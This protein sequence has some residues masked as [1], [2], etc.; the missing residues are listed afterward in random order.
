MNNKNQHPLFAE[1]RRERIVLLLEEKGKLVVPEL[2]EAFEVSP[3][4][5]RG[6]LRELEGKGR[7]KRAHG[8]AMTLGKTGFERNSVFQGIVNMEEKRRIAEYAR[9]L[10]NDGDTIILDTGTT[11]LE[12]AKLLYE[13]KNLTVVTNDIIIAAHLESH[14]DANIIV[15]G[16][17]LRRGYHCTTGSRAI[18]ALKDL[19]V[20]KA[21]MASNALSLEKGFTTPNFEQAEVKRQMLSIALRSIMLIDSSKLGR[22]SFLKF[23]DISDIDLLITDNS[24]W[25]GFCKSLKDMNGDLE[26]VTV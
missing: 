12:L 21:F 15:A 9:S 24:A 20:D 16:G 25:K 11:T 1:E 26:I 17:I 10:V 13:K 23:A 4:T 3:A 8:G 19:T 2:C 14:S 7:L 5:I 22:V 18:S 6:D